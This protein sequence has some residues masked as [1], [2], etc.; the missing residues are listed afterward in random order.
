VG[1]ESVTTKGS[2]HACENATNLTGL[3][4]SFSI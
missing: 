2:N 3:G 4:L 1:S